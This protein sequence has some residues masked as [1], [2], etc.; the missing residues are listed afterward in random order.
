MAEMKKLTKSFFE[1]KFLLKDDR[2]DKAWKVDQVLLWSNIIAFKKDDNSNIAG[3]AS[4]SCHRGIRSGH[5]LITSDIYYCIRNNFTWILYNTQFW[6]DFAG[7]KDFFRPQFFC[8]SFKKEKIHKTIWSIRISDYDLDLRFTG[9]ATKCQTV[10]LR[11][12]L[13]RWNQI[14]ENHPV[15][16]ILIWAV[17]SILANNKIGS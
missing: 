16:N 7:K 10:S 3:E 8:T 9:I 4:S 6:M 15:L 17:D 14:Q 13:K 11:L 5:L 12:H 1:E 2:N